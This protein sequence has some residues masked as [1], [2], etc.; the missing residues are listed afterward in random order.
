MT[1]P[2]AISIEMAL[3][4]CAHGILIEP[5]RGLSEHFRPRIAA[6]GGGVWGANPFGI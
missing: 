1:P 2:H 3:T 5:R 6:C 4:K